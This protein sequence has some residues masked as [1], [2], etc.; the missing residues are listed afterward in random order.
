MSLTINL[1]KVGI[2]PRGAWGSGVANYEY[3]D[4]VTY[5]GSSY[6]VILKP[7]L[8]PAGTVPTNATYFQKLADKGDVGAT[9]ATGATGPTGPT[10]ATGAAGA[11]GTIV[12]TKTV[13][14]TGKNIFDKS[15]IS[16][17]L[18]GNADG[19]LIS[20]AN[21]RVSDFMPVE[22]DMD[23]SISGRVSANNGVAFYDAAKALIPTP[24]YG[25][26]ESGA[27]WASGPSNGVYHTT[28]T[29]KFMRVNVRL[30][31]TG[32]LGNTM[33]VE[34]GSIA[35]AY[36]AYR[37]FTAVDQVG[38]PQVLPDDS[39]TLG[40]VA[41][42]IQ[43]ERNRLA[44]AE[45]PSIYK[46]DKG[47]YGLISIPPRSDWFSDATN[48]ITKETDAYLL[49]LGVVNN[50]T[51][52]ATIN[53]PNATRNIF[54]IKNYG[55]LI[56]GKFVQV[57]FHVK[58]DPAR[59]K[60]DSCYVRKLD[61][62]ANTAIVSGNVKSEIRLV[63]TGVYEVRKSFPVPSTGS[64]GGVLI[65]SLFGNGGTAPTEELAVSGFMCYL[66]DTDMSYTHTLTEKSPYVI[67]YINES[68]ESAK[69]DGVYHNPKL[70]G[71]KLNA[72]GDSLTY[73]GTDLIA[74]QA[75]AY[76][77]LVADR[78]GMRIN[79]YGI[80]S[81]Q[82]GGLG[83]S[84][85]ATAMHIRYT[86]MADD[87]DIITF[88]GGTNDC[89]APIIPL[90]TVSD[91]DGSTFFGALKILCNGLLNKYPGKKI[92]AITP[93]N[94][95][96]ADAALPYVNAVIQVCGMY[97]IPVLDLYR[98]GGIYPQNAA[99][100]AALMRN[101]TDTIHPGPTGHV[102]WADRYEAFLLSL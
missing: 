21:G 10:G 24:A 63:S 14:G 66:S 33:Q 18:V 47:N 102:I 97:A 65:G 23:Y 3:L 93:M 56:D 51:L 90:G 52:P 69:T 25:T 45:A 70:Y 26:L 44:V 77:G 19:V 6:M 7:G 86:D 85:G 5:L 74:D 15:T 53:L 88:F 59:F 48:F 49:S 38:T 89:K 9:G 76:C 68:R 50:I 16:A 61:G 34:K 98:N 42:W 58:G 95:L 28:P 36:E 1:G 78:Y 94:F 83:T 11:S 54:L 39:V 40:V 73:S 32:E 55:F 43:A 8:V 71:K 82:L 20:S 2:T 64:F 12:T 37:S 57:V 75:K 29:T 81:N 80:P 87:A 13:K 35:T 72:L 27:T 31:N 99:Q 84:G 30:T 60:T 101:G 92:G 67:K 96:A 100:K 4:T 62:S 46:Q 22:S 79:N 41:S 91:S 17:F